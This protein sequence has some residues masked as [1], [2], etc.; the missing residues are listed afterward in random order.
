MCESLDLFLIGRS[1]HHDIDHFR[2]YAG[3]IFHQFSA[4][5]L[6]VRFGEEECVSAHLAHAG[7]ESDTGSG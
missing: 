7:L 3:S 2:Q 5:E 6:G 1:D 4:A